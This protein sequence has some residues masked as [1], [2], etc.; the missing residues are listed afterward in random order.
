MLPETALKIKELVAAGAAIVSPKPVKSP[1]LKDYPECD[2]E[3]KK[4]AD[5]A[6]NSSVKNSFGKG[7][8]F[9][10][11]EDAIKKAGIVPDFIVEKASSPDYIKIG[12][13]TSPDV[14][15]YFV[16][17]LAETRQKIAVSFLISGK[18]PELW[19]AENGNIT[20]APVWEERDGRTKLELIL[21]GTQSVFVAFRKP[22]SKADHP[23]SVLVSDSTANWNVL[24]DKNGNAV[25]GSQLPLEAKVFYASGKEKTINTNPKPATEI[26]GNWKVSF[27][28]KTDKSFELDFP[29]L[30]DFSIHSN[31]AVNYFAGTATYRKTINIGSGLLEKGQKIMLDLGEMNDI[32]EVKVNGKNLG[33]LWYPPYSVDVTDALKTGENE[34]EIAVTNNWANRLIGDEQEPAD[35]EWGKD[36][37]EKMGRAMLAYPEWFVKNQPRPSQG[38]KTFSVWYYYRKDS[39]LKP[40]GLVGPVRL[41]IESEVKL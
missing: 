37:G 9:T 3:L 20:D 8:I 11:L 39:P 13:R 27:V 34:L 6:W 2:S 40:A 22:A 12:H 30:I 14:E 24:S 16:A 38:R 23:I 33:V 29:G 4:I 18:Q 15:I 32:A 31:T 26:L 28:P 10:K 36:R 25:I 1:S 17:N 5:E 19:Q 21:K 35:F 41:V 7:F